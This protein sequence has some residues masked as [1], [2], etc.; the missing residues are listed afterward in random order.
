MPLFVVVERAGILR[1]Y[2]GV[3]PHG[4]HLEGDALNFLVA[5]EGKSAKLIEN[6]SNQTG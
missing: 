3:V 2:E 1:N 5:M 6:E 4:Y